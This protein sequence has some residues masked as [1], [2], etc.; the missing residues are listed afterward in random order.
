[1]KL[2]KYAEYIGRSHRLLSGLSKKTGS[3]VIYHWLDFLWCTC[4][5]GAIINHY[6]RGGFYQLKGCERRKSMTYLRILR[7]Y[8]KL[9]NPES[10]KILNDKHLFN[11]HF[12]PF[13]KRKWLYSSDMTFEQFCSLCDS[14]EMLIIKPE[15]GVEGGGVRKLPP[16][17]A[18]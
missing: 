4:V 10:I 9:N 14:C 1:M 13:V 7:A 3:S 15:N 17:P 12:A 8:S 5:H 2:K 18:S 11:A 16:P 6:V